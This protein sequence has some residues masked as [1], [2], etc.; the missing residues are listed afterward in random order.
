MF[1]YLTNEWASDALRR[2]PTVTDSALDDLSSYITDV[3]RQLEHVIG[4]FSKLDESIRD[5]VDSKLTVSY[6]I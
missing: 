5:D 4:E 6:S 1:V 3:P 2:I